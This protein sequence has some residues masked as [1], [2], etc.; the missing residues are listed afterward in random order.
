[1]PTALD[2]VLVP[3]ALDLIERFGLMATFVNVT[4]TTYDPATGTAI[5]T[6]ANVQRKVAPPGE[7]RRY[8]PTDVTRS[9]ATVSYV[10]ASGLTFVPQQGG[11]LTIATTTWAIL[12]VIAWYSGELIACYEL[13]L[14]G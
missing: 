13:E 10:A 6:T 11:I 1:M 8:A 4:A 2:A 9:K 14:G 5:Q 12:G 7:R 3:V